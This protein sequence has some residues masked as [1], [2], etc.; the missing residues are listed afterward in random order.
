MLFINTGILAQQEP[1]NKHSISGKLLLDTIW[2]PVVYLSYIPSFNNMYTMAYEMIIENSIIDS[3]GHFSF[4]TD[5]LPVQDNLYRIHVSKKGD[6]PA[7]LIIGG[8]EENHIFFIA[9]NTSNIFISNRSKNTLFK[10]VSITAYYPNKALQQ[11]DEIASYIDSANFNGSTL[12]RE[13]ITKAIYGKLRFIADTSTHPLISLYALYK[14]KFESDYSVNQQFYKN[15]LKKWD[16]E[17]STYFTSFRSQLPLSNNREILYRFIIGFVFLCIGFVLSIYLKSRTSNNKK[18]E[19][20]SVQE[21]RIFNLIRLGMSNKEISDDCNI[22]LSTV[23]S[24]LNSI[25]SKLNIKSRKEA[26]NIKLLS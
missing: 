26:M 21:R 13:F 1:L 9:N 22:G 19:T 8:K 16:H 25:Y 2:E 7:S 5:Y 10:K 24:H 11:V 3:S 15:Y 23:K 6:P 4:N 20:L 17:K 18:M 14:S 12:K